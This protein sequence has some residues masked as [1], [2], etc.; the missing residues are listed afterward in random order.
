[1]SSC[2]LICKPWYIVLLCSD[3]T[4]DQMSIYLSTQFFIL[5]WCLCWMYSIWS[6]CISDWGLCIGRG[7]PSLGVPACWEREQLLLAHNPSRL[8]TGTVGAGAGGAKLG[9]AAW[10]PQGCLLTEGW[11]HLGGMGACLL[12]LVSYKG[13]TW[14]LRCWHWTSRIQGRV[15]PKWIP[16]TFNS[17]HDSFPPQTKI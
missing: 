11:Q 10:P 9:R 17:L 8:G 12:S 4:A 7:I 1:M 6:S 15:R 16:A 13:T 14:K 2:K 5:I 3:C